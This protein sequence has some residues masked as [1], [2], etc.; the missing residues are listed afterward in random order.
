MSVSQGEVLIFR[1]NRVKPHA[2]PK[3]DEESHIGNNHNRLEAQIPTSS[4]KSAEPL[5]ENQTSIFNW[6]NVCFEVPV[7]GGHQRLLDQVDGW[8][9][10]GT[11]TA[12]M[13]SCTF[14]ILAS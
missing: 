5:Q 13:V 9:K 1:R 14:N 8:V 7:K 10:P 2:A 11:L 3:N 6:R 12:L 4:P